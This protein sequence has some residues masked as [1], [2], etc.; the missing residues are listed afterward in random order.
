[1]SVALFLRFK[2]RA[3]RELAMITLL[4][5]LVLILLLVKADSTWRPT[6]RRREI[7]LILVICLILYLMGVFR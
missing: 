7:G 6:L 5:I 3:L 1:M 2:S 4:I